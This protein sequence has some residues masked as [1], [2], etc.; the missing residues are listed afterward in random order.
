MPR[1]DSNPGDIA[2][3]PERE[4]SGRPVHDGRLGVYAALGG[5]AG[6]IAIPWVPIAVLKRI[7]GALLNDLATGHGLSLTREAREMLSE[8][9]APK[10]ARG[11]ALRA[12]RIA[13][14]EVA[15]RALKA[16]GPVGLFL[17]LR[18]AVQ[19]Y[20]LGRL[21]DRYLEQRGADQGFVIDVQEAAQIRAAIDGALA[22]AV[23]V[24][25]MART[26]GVGSEDDLDPT[27]AWVDRALQ[28]VARVP[29]RLTRRLDAGFD[30]LIAHDGN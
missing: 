14:N 2:M 21:F 3:A 20:V 5:Y 1:P 15:S 26:A 19:T 29:S 6:T 18:G 4:R 25:V 8:P 28:R 17:P 23:T 12:L 7:R 13:G 10:Q 22:R 16:L 11:L 30:D 9:R 24:D 27:A